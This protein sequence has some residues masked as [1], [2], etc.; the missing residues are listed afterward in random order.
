MAEQEWKNL[1]VEDRAGVRLLTFNRPKALNALNQ[2][3]LEELSEI[4]TRTAQDGSVGVVILTGAGTRAFIAGAD[5]REMVDIDLEQARE[6]SQRGHRV[7]AQIEALPQVVIAAV[8]G[9]ALGGG[10][11]ISLACDFIYASKKA[12]FGLPE[13]SLGL[14]PGFG[15]TQRL[16]RKIPVGLARELVLSGDKISAEEALRIGLANRVFENPE[17]LLEAAFETAELILSRS[18]V[19]VSAAKRAMVQGHDLPLA[20]GCALEVEAFAT[21]FNTDHPKEGTRAFLEKRTPSF[22]DAPGSK[23]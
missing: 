6:L 8:N 4:L 19:A 9:Y 14:I 18:H 21:L 20:Q 3:T 23:S 12:V 16:S 1:L 22:P 11:E 15:G 10:L 7:F 2:E 13:V 5:I 17:A